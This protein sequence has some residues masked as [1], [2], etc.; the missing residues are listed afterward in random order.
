MAKPHGFD[1]VFQPRSIAVVGASNTAG[2]VGKAVMDNLLWGGYEGQ[3]YPV[4]LKAVTFPNLT[5]FPSLK[6][7][8]QPIDLSVIIV[9]AASVPK[10]MEQVAA[11]GC[12]AA[13]IISAGFKEVGPAGAKLEEE[14]ASICH[15]HGIVLIGPNCLGVL[16]PH[17]KL[18]ASFAGAPAEKGSIAFVSQSGALCTAVLDM[19]T[20]LGLGF[21]KFVSIG[22]KA[23]LH[24]L[25]MLHYLSD[26]PETKV[27]LWYVEDLSPHPSWV[28]QVR[29]ITHNPAHPKP[30]IMFKAGRTHTG[31][32]ASLSH[33]GS[34]AGN[35]QT[36][37]AFMQQAG[38]SRANSL[39]QMFDLASVFVH[40]EPPK[41]SGTLIVT[42]AGGPGIV[43]ADAAEL[44]QVVLAELNPK[45][46]KALKKIVPFTAN[47]HNPLDLIGDATAERYKEALEIVG[48]DPNC[49]NL[50]VIL[51]PQAMTDAVGSAQAVISIQ[52]QFPHLSTVAV[53]MGGEIV[54]SGVVMLQRAGIATVNQ[55]DRAAAALGAMIQYGEWVHKPLSKPSAIT[56]HTSEV[57]KALHALPKNTELL[58]PASVGEVLAGYGIAMA[59][60]G[61]AHSSAEAVSRAH[62]M[63]SPV[64]LKVISPD[65]SHKSDVGGVLLNVPFEKVAEQYD[66]LLK[67]VRSK[68]SGAKIHGVL[69]Q[70][71][72]EVGQELIIGAKRDPVFGPVL[73]FGLGGIYVEV[74][75][76]VVFGIAPLSLAEATQ[77]T[78][79]IR[80][81]AIMR[82]ARGHKPLDTEAVAQII[83]QV[84]NLMLNHP[85]INE[86]DLNPVIVGEKGHGATALDAR[87]IIDKNKIPLIN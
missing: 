15:D 7:I 44:N 59:A 31:A 43:A 82:G 22:N 60:S 37:A 49:G 53:F 6:A 28:E 20:S 81:S 30:I 35:D 68:A 40:N 9:P 65:V 50:L 83:V 73:M 45:T 14:V 77:M 80:A 19:A 1:L 17:A 24:E 18:N 27:I 38:V 55:P 16:N 64:A 72:V 51:T 78:A 47:I 13:I 3:I 25:D 52:K 29:K 8:E 58:E 39:D 12:K 76:D 34:L 32:Y 21:S 54:R 11:V 42:N 46:E 87:I 57:T 84:S 67:S 4:N 75:H 26:D 56:G 79:R 71:M 48:H 23:L 10:V 33:T 69:V 74:L 63:R 66:V 61:V 2:S 41:K 36:Y 5:S 70:Q 62:E 86:I 85:Q